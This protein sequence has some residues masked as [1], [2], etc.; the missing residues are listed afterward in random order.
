MRRH[1]VNYQQQII[2]Q[3]FMQNVIGIL[4][5]P[6]EKNTNSDGEETQLRFK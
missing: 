3:E 2:R 4:V 1:K 5:E 6:N